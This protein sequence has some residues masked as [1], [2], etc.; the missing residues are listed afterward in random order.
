MTNIFLTCDYMDFP[1]IYTHISQ[2][3]VNA[4]LNSD[5]N[6]IALDFTLLE[7]VNVAD[8][9]HALQDVTLS[10]YYHHF[11]VVITHVGVTHFF[12]FANYH[13]Y[14]DDITRLIEIE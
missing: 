1:A 4:I 3:T 13:A 12:K 7:S 8:F 10:Q 5:N 14:T 11:D 6:G 9:F 2:Y